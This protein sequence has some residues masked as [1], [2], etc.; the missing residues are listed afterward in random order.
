MNHSVALPHPIIPENYVTVRMGLT[1][2]A[3]PTWEELDAAVMQYASRNRATATLPAAP[4][5]PPVKRQISAA[6]RKRIAAATKRRWEAK[7]KADALAK[8]KSQPVAKAKTADKPKSMAAS[9]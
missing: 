8:K 9:A 5:A 6:G 3:S 4:A 2:I 7:R 1:L